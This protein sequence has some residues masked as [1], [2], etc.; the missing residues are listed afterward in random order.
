MSQWSPAEKAAFYAADQ[1]IT[2]TVNT[3]VNSKPELTASAAAQVL[4]VPALANENLG[5]QAS[6]QASLTDADRTAISLSNNIMD[7]Q[8]KLA[9]ATVIYQGAA[10]AVQLQSQGYTNAA[11]LITY[12]NLQ[13]DGVGS[14]NAAAVYLPTA[15]TQLNQAQQNYNTAWTNFENQTGISHDQALNY[16]TQIADASSSNQSVAQQSQIAATTPASDTSSNTSQGQPSQ[17]AANWQ[18]QTPNGMILDSNKPVFTDNSQPSQNA[19]NWQNQTPN[20]MILDSNKPVFTDNSQGSQNAATSQGQPSQ[21][22]A[23]SATPAATGWF[24]TSTTTPGA[25]PEAPSDSTPASNMTASTTPATTPASDTTASTNSGTGTG[26]ISSLP[27]EEQNNAADDYEHGLD[28][29]AAQMEE[30]MKEQPGDQDANSSSSASDTTTAAEQTA[31]AGIKV[32]TPASD[33]T[34]GA[35]TGG[36]DNAPMSSDQLEAVASNYDV[37]AGDVLE[38][39]NLEAIYKGYSINQPRSTVIQVTSSQVNHPT[40]VMTVPSTQVQAPS[41]MINMPSMQVNVP[42]SQV[43]VPSSQVQ[44][45]SDLIDMPSLQIDFPSELIDMPSDAMTSLDLQPALCGH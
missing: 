2:N 1:S 22:A 31:E 8:T 39:A 35:A 19:A 34:A 36:N 4:A 43:N 15:L 40:D 30:M 41:P 16:S 12:L 33:T 28:K 29:V 9:A 7:A 25:T 24:R 26:S 23:Q 21:N 44:T 45:P 20:G 13:V 42:S 3:T 17:N 32:E 37:T 11:D 18:N 38:V 6:V 5:N 14:T 10:T 27:K